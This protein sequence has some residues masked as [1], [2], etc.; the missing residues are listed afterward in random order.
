MPIRDLISERRAVQVGARRVL[1]RKPTVAT[2]FTV[3][4]LYW[5][6]IEACLNVWRDPVKR[7]AD[8]LAAFLPIFLKAGDLR[9]ADLLATLTDDPDP[10]DAEPLFR[11][12]LSLCDL[13]RIVMF[14][15][16]SD[17]PDKTQTSSDGS[18]IDDQGT[19]MVLVAE[20][21]HLDPMTLQ[22]WP[23][24]AYLTIC[25]VLRLANDERHLAA[26]VGSR[27]LHGETKIVPV[28]APRTGDLILAY[29]DGIH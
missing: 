17:D 14:L 12:A 23:F 6:E 26:Q 4:G 29:D 9:H 18:D 5:P 27:P 20:R 10:G 19:A 28:T 25:E 8:P 13:E 2:V 21:L 1:I 7:P 3:L 11:A 16:F 22:H 24:E 15:G